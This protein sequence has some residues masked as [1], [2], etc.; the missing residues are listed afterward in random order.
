MNSTRPAGKNEVY[1]GRYEA[2]RQIGQGGMGKIFLG[3]QLDQPRSVVIKVM[4]PEIAA[5]PRFR[6][7]FAREMRLMTR[8]HHP[9]AVALYDGSLDDA[10]RSCIVME[11]VT[12][13]TLNDLLQRHG[14]L[15]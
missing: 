11:F 2:L 3:R 7:D 12:G 8:F 15:P 13:I 14:R 9:N 6:Q 5:D 4:H 1:L 10:G